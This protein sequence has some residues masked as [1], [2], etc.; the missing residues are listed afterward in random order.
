VWWFFMA[1][2]LSWWHNYGC[3]SIH[4]IWILTLS[5][6]IFYVIKLQVFFKQHIHCITFI[7][8]KGLINFF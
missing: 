1:F 5:S 7:C 3:Y 4:G 8:Q 6:L 2:T